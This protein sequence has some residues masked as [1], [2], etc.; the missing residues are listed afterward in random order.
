MYIQN[1]YKSEFNWVEKRTIIRYLEA[2]NANHVIFTP[3]CYTWNK[4][5]FVTMNSILIDSPSTGNR[6]SI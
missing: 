4:H 6:V 5:W 2:K 1:G 3:E